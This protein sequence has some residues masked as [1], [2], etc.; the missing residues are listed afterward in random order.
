MGVEGSKGEILNRI[1]KY[2]YYILAKEENDL[3]KICLEYQLSRTQK[4]KATI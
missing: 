2:Y 3:V 4:E 1:V